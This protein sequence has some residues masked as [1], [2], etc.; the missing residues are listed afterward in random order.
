MAKYR[1]LIFVIATFQEEH[2]N[3]LMYQLPL[4]NTWL[5][6]VFH[7]MEEAKSDKSGGGRFL[8]DYSISQLTLDDV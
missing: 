5:P 6:D 4:K 1:V 8:E 3:Q 7:L 2:M